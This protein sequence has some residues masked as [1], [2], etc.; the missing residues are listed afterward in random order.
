MNK[1]EHNYAEQKVLEML[2]EL[3]RFCLE[4]RAQLQNL[5]IF[6]QAKLGNRQ[7]SI[8]SGQAKVLSAMVAFAALD[9][10]NV[11]RMLVQAVG[12]MSDPDMQK[13]F[14]KTKMEQRMGTTPSF[15]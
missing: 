12:M 11:R 8:C 5:D 6:L 1:N 13:A 15:S 3:H 14:R 9:S 10:E 2:E 4:H 7:L